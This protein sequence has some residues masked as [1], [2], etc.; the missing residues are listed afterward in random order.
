MDAVKNTGVP[1]MNVIAG[2]FIRPTFN[3]F[4]L[5]LVIPEKSVKEIPRIPGTAKDTIKKLLAHKN[6]VKK[7]KV[8]KNV[9]PESAMTPASK[10][11]LQS[12]DYEGGIDLGGSYTMEE[13]ETEVTIEEAEETD[14]EENED[15]ENQ[16]DHERSLRGDVFCKFLHFY[17]GFNAN[18]Y[19]NTKKI[20]TK[21][22]SYFILIYL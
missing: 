9:I 17:T 20:V 6:S 14:K 5:V 13:K 4:F 2:W 3:I 18:I 8:I 1:F 21:H 22:Y 19:I 11:H 15:Y 16:I 12:L 7:H 10:T